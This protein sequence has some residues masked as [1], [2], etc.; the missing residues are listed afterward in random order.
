VAL[1]AT[2][3]ARR[4]AGRQPMSI[5]ISCPAG[6]T[7]ANPPHAAAAVGR[8]NRQTDGH[9]TV[10]QTLPHTMPTV[11]VKYIHF[12]EGQTDYFSWTVI[13][14]LDTFLVDNRL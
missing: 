1:L 6:P 2:V 13:I 14:K 9:R 11:L 7:A 10:T 3:A 5:D 8:W 12:S 4:A